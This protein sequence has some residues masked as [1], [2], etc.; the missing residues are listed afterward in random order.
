MDP[1]SYEKWQALCLAKADSFFDAFACTYPWQCSLIFWLFL[2]LLLA[3]MVK[4]LF[5][6]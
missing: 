4:F 1:I 2:I 5:K 6:K 3:L